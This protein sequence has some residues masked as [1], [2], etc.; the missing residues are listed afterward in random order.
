[1]AGNI[2]GRWQHDP[3]KEEQGP[4][5]VTMNGH[6]SY[7]VCRHPQHGGVFLVSVWCVLA[8]F[9]LAP[10]G[11]DLA[12]EDETLDQHTTRDQSAEI[13]RYNAGY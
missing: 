13:F 12:M 8:A 4:S 6:P 9:D 11:Q 10:P 3:P 7:E 2:V 5:F 1:M